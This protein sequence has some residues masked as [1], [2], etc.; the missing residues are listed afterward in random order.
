[1]WGLTSYQQSEQELHLINQSWQ[2]LL[3]PISSTAFPLPLLL[4]PLSF[5]FCRYPLHPLPTFQG[6]CKHRVC[7]SLGCFKYVLHT[8]FKKKKK[9]LKWHSDAFRFGS[10][11]CQIFPPHHSERILSQSGDDKIYD[12][13]AGRANSGAAQYWEKWFCNFCTSWDI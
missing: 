6:L 9:K 11:G 1:M 12:S 4:L 7:Y 10:K 3:G 2:L 13:V 5:T 8:R